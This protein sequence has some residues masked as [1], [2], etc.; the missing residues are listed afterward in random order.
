[1][2]YVI[3]ESW[4]KGSR[5]WTPGW[6]A[7]RICC[8]DSHARILQIYRHTSTSCCSWTQKSNSMRSCSSLSAGVFCKTDKNLN[9]LINNIIFLFSSSILDEDCVKQY[10]VVGTKLKHSKWKTFNSDYLLSRTFQNAIA[11]LPR[12]DV[13]HNMKKLKEQKEALVR[14]RATVP[15]KLHQYRQLLVQH[16][17]LE[18][19]QREISQWLDRAEESLRTT[20]ETRR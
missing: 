8:Q 16:E 13:E 5:I 15:V 9:M 1:M 18:S 2:R 4:L 17:S 3:A 7:L 12:D 10:G 20:T 6:S 14:V 11:E 19:G